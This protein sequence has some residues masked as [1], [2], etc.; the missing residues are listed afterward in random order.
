MTA[1]PLEFGVP[2]PD[3][4]VYVP[5]EIRDGLKRLAALAQQNPVAQSSVEIE[6]LAKAGTPPKITVK[7]YAA[8]TDEAAAIA[9]RT[10]DELVARYAQM[11]AGQP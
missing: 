9:Q 2:A 11:A 7:T 6:Q 1:T 10:Y 8:T 4:A 5:A 3:A